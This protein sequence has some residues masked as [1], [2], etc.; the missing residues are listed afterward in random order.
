MTEIYE[1]SSGKEWRASADAR[2]QAAGLQRD[3]STATISKYYLREEAKRRGKKMASLGSWPLPEFDSRKRQ[4]HFRKLALQ[5][6]RPLRREEKQKTSSLSL[7]LKI[8]DLGRGRSHSVEKCCQ[9]QSI[10]SWSAYGWPK[11][12]SQQVWMTWSTHD[13]TLSST[14]WNLRLRSKTVKGTAK[15]IGQEFMSKTDPL[16]KSSTK[17]DMVCLQADRLCARSTQTS[18][19]TE[20][21]GLAIGA[22]GIAELLNQHRVA[23]RQLQTVQSSLGRDVV[24][25]G[26]RCGWRD[27]WKFVRKTAPKV[28]VHEERLVSLDHSD[29]LLRKGR[30]LRGSDTEPIDLSDDMER[31]QRIPQRRWNQKQSLQIVDLS[32]LMF[33]RLEVLLRTQFLTEGRKGQDTAHDVLLPRGNSADQQNAREPEDV[34]LRKMFGLRVS[35]TRMEIVAVAEIVTVDILRTVNISKIKVVRWKKELPVFFTHKRRLVHNFERRIIH[36]NHC[37][38]TRATWKPDAERSNKLRTQDTQSTPENS[39]GKKRESVVSHDQPRV[40]SGLIKSILK[41]D[42]DLRQKSWASG[43]LVKVW[44]VPSFGV[45]RPY[46]NVIQPRAQ[47]AREKSTGTTI[48]SLIYRVEWGARRVGQAQAYQLHKSALQDKKDTAVMSTKQTS[49]EVTSLQRQRIPWLAWRYIRKR[50]S[51]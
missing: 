10:P 21:R 22:T 48:W 3:S 39:C 45:K 13:S 42:K 1:E 31:H 6:K 4:Q 8:S 5:V 33:E 50:R 19:L 11:L 36:R 49:S 35:T 46:L 12:M 38:C 41:W 44:S 25:P 7:G 26:Q 15:I 28:F 51:T 24:I 17:K 2:V 18:I 20:P 37:G 47:Q 32:G 27:V 14:W 9:N 30:Y 29:I 16:G 43:S 34:Q 40:T 23:K